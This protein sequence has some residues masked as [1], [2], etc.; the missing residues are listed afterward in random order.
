MLIAVIIGNKF[1]SAGLYHDDRIHL[2]NIRTPTTMRMAIAV[3]R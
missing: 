2:H 1:Y 3:D